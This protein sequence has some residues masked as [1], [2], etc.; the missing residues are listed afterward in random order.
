MGVMCV[1]NRNIYLYHLNIISLISLT[2]FSNL[3]LNISL[4]F[5]LKLSTCGRVSTQFCVSVS[6]RP[7]YGKL[8]PLPLPSGLYFPNTII[9]SF[10]SYFGSSYSGG[11][12][13]T[14]PKWNRKK[15]HNILPSH[16][17]C[18]TAL[19]SRCRK[20]LEPLPIS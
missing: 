11:S 4:A 8:T 10:N 6:S 1:K 16:T 2:S 18:K 5:Y 3:V 9:T 19:F 15:E 14:I 20:G 12:L 17:S 13:P 7:S